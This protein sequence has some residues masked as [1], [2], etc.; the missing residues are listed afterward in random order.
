MLDPLYIDLP[1]R[2]SAEFTG[3]LTTLDTRGCYESLLRAAILS[4][5]AVVLLVRSKPSLPIRRFKKQFDESEW[6]SVGARI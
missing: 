4:T 2:Y 6:S 3:F 1:N 5:L